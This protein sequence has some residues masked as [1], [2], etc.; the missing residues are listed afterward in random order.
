MNTK[1]TKN[2]LV[3][4][5]EN[6]VMIAPLSTV[7]EYKWK[8]NLIS[9]EDQLFS[10]IELT[11]TLP[12]CLIIDLSL[13]TDINKLKELIKTYT[14]STSYFIYKFITHNKEEYQSIAEE[15]NQ[16]FS[17]LFFCSQKN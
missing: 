1:F 11:K 17:S 7:T 14:F 4:I 16:W 5:N 12:S 2:N 6:L 10:H 8:T 9:N 3:A 15:F 13:F